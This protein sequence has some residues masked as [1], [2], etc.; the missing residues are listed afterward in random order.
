MSV[1]PFC[2]YLIWS[3]LNNSAACY[4]DIEIPVGESKHSLNTSKQPPWRL[5]SAEHKFLTGQYCDSAVNRKNQFLSRGPERILNILKII[6]KHVLNILII[7]GIQ[8]TDWAAA[9]CYRWKP[10]TVFSLCRDT[11][12]IGCK[13]P[14]KVILILKS[15]WAYFFL[16]YL[17]LS[18][19]FFFKS[20]AWNFIMSRLDITVAKD[21]VCLHLFS[22]NSCLGWSQP[23]MPWDYFGG[24]VFKLDV[25][26][27]LKSKITCDYAWVSD[28]QL[29][30]SC[31][32]G[33]TSVN[34]SRWQI[35][36]FTVQ[37]C[38]R[39]DS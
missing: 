34:W 28:R 8:W 27:I 5:Y 4:N 33:V 12:H 17:N 37:L 24:I 31:L 38:C 39:R 32:L 18:F 19:F 14:I 9:S 23:V 35:K 10:T 16:L 15:H 11:K 25:L 7:S 29:S 20:E 13:H 36:G 22:S 6:R 2:L 26:I 21:K 30:S 1:C 3:Y